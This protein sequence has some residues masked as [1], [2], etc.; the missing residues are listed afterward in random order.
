MDVIEYQRLEAHNV[1]FM[2]KSLWKYNVA[3]FELKDYS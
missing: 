2:Q 1:L 3:F